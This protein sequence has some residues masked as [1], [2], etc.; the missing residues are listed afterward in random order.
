MRRLTA[1]AAALTLAATLAACGGDDDG[2]DEGGNEP[3]GSA[4]DGVKTGGTF[5]YIAENTDESAPLNP[6]VG[7]ALSKSRDTINS[8]TL[9]YA[10]NS[11]TEPNDFYPG[12]AESW[13]IAPDY[14]EVTIHLHPDAKWSD[15]EDVNAEDVVLSY[16]IA[17]TRGAG[18]FI[19]TPGAAGAVGE[20]EVIDDK[21]I[22]FTQDPEN[23]VNTFPRGIMSVTIVPEHVWGEVLPAD[24]DEQL[25]TAQGEGAGADAARDAI[26]AIAEDVLAFAPDEDVSA[27]PF[28]Y[29]RASAS[30][31][32]YTK[33]E[34]FYAADNVAPDQ[35][36]LKNYTGNQQIWDLVSSGDVDGTIFVATPQDVMDGFNANDNVGVAEAYSPVVAGWA[37]N[38]SVAPYD[39]VR[40]RQALAYAVDRDQ[41]IAIG[42]PTAGTAPIATTGM[43]S[44]AFTEWLGDDVESLGLNPY[45]HDPA[46]AERLLTDAGFSKDGDQ[47]LLPS[48]EPWQV[49]FQVVNGF[50]DWI[51]V[52]E[53][54][55]TQLNEFGISAQTQ[56]SPDF[57]VYQEEMA[58]GKY[59]MGFWLLGLTPSPYD[60]Y[61]RIYGQT[62]GW[63]VL[64]NSLDY[65]P[66]GENGNWMGGPET[67]EVDGET[68]NP[69]ELTLSLRN[70]ALEGKAEDILKLAKITNE[71][72]P[73]IQ[74]W[75]YSNTWFYTNSNF[76]GFENV[77]DDAQR[78]RIGVWMMQG[79]ISAK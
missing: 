20:V 46:E 11:L 36:V 7:A 62:S 5:T 45:A 70:G 58:A 60:V 50:S 73:I 15:G 78:F 30:D 66:P 49:T 55:V 67:Y 21:T 16:K 47:W 37:F 28:V 10:K 18:A 56:T 3:T 9:G 8:L 69:G 35:L 34:Y 38:Q 43:H 77:P 71:N 12:L 42:T 64:G 76:E 25:A 17:Y 68:V 29:E 1:L 14:S 40:V 22:K 39:D 31:L 51:A 44:E 65:S 74:F 61:Q 2:D 59:D 53:N 24:F 79:W 13:E 27:G 48:G 23:P 4:E 63:T 54:L 6:F 41:A 75:D 57:A 33:N 19:L 26:A 52:A 32:L 72:L